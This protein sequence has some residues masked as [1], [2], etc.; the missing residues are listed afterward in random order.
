V[1]KCHF[2]NALAWGQA[3]AQEGGV[4]PSIGVWTIEEV[5]T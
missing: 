4:I 2:P 5:S 1:L 3:I